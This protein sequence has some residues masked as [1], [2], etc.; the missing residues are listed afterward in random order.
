MEATLKSGE[1]NIYA[2]RRFFIDEDTWQIAVSELYDGRGQLW[3]VGQSML[4]QQYQK[5]VPVYAFEAL[6]DIIAGRYLA[7]GMN[8]EEKSAIQYGIKSSSADFTP[9]ALRNAG[10][11]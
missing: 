10:V 9:A 7:I 4:V 8:N 2:K 11:R 1:R 3:R 5:Q 6:Y